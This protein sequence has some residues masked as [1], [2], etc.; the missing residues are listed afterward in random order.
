MTK[1]S[2]PALDRLLDAVRLRARRQREADGV[3]SLAS[4]LGRI[5][6]LGWQIVIP[7]L[8]GLAIGRWLDHRFGTVI[9]WTAPLL[10]L[11]VALG[12]WS[13]WAW[14]KRQ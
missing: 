6:V 11:G 8:I 10:I 4:G 2:R 9:F 12:C 3:P 7:A 1:P 5:G 14:I 13:G